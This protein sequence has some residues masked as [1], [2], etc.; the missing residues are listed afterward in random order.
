[1]GSYD[2]GKNEV[3]AWVR[4]RF[5]VSSTIL[6]VGACDGKWRRILPEYPAMDA[7]EV[8]DGYLDRLHGY[9][10]IFH[11]DICDFRY[12]WY[13]LIIFGD[14]IEHLSV[15]QAQEV[16]K[17]A[18]PRCKDMIVAVPWLYY[19]GPVNGNVHEIHIQDDLTPEL[20]DRRYPGFKVLCHPREDYCYFVKGD[21][22]RGPE[23]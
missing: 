23:E 17:Y 20:F 13:D 8:F 22:A 12:E 18:W 10:Q 21:D 9:R 6:D 4:E 7:V 1:M 19:Q 2:F 3:C 11:A 5:P 16:L 15:E 14:V